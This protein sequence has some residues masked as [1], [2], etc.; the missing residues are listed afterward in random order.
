MM[1]LLKFCNK[2]LN[3]NILKIFGM[4]AFTCSLSFGQSFKSI[5]KKAYHFSTTNKDSAIY[6]AK[7][8]V[9]MAKSN[10]EKYMAF[11]MLGNTATYK[12]LN[13]LA[14]TGYRQAMKYSNI[15]EKYK[16]YNSL[17]RRM[18]YSGDNEK[19]LKIAEE[20]IIFFKENNADI[21]LS[22][23]YDLKANILL[24]KGDISS[25]WY[26][27]KS[28][29]LKND[30]EVGFTY[31][32]LANALYR[33]NM[34]DSAIHYQQLAMQNYPLKDPDS[35]AENYA[36]LAKYMATSDGHENALTWL[37]KAND[38]ENKSSKVRSILSSA[39]LLYYLKTN[40][41]EE[42]V[43]ESAKLNMLLE[44][45][46]S[47]A[48]NNV[49]KR[50]Y[51]KVARDLCRDVIKANPE[52]YIKTSMKAK[53]NEYNKYEIGYK[54]GREHGRNEQKLIN[55][56]FGE[57]PNKSGTD[58]ILTIFFAIVSAIMLVLHF[59]KIRWRKSKEIRKVNEIRKDKTI[60]RIEELISA[61]LDNTNISIIKM[62]QD[63]LGYEEIAEQLDM[64]D[65][66]V[67]K[68]MI[69]LAKRLNRDGITD[70][71]YFL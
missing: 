15:Q 52:E 36:K 9:K 10:N 23:A 71:R 43:R 31:A 35:R 59:V 44:I 69:R 42:L 67:R 6:N 57:K 70:I 53:L 4:L 39:Y 41:K 64:K 45:M 28:A 34:I 40:D 21:S 5:Y 54:K 48:T 2:R 51:I 29:K 1:H 12:G 65:G 55:E 38:Q 27:K 8:L 61:R 3:T 49:D 62:L 37:K 14:M 63:N 22:Y 68:R 50:S 18:Y 46:I 60:E 24:D 19:A 16:V 20:C 30:K 47:S 56:I 7:K 25:F 26:F 17:G 66:T 11:H 32:Q 58:R 13:N 33:F